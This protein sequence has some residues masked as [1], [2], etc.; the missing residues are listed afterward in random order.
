MLR[1]GLICLLRVYHEVVSPLLPTACRFHPSCST[2]FSDAVRKHGILRGGWLGFCRLA[3]C[4]P[5]HP[6]G[7]D[8][9][10]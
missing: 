6:G 9:V 7:Y 8:P 10:R 1:M 4:H 5:A 3:R 2:Y